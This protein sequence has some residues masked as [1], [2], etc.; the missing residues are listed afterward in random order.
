[1]WGIYYQTLGVSAGK[2]LGFH[3][4]WLLEMNAMMFVKNPPLSQGSF[5]EM[6]EGFFPWKVGQAEERNRTSL[7]IPNV[8]RRSFSIMIPAAAQCMLEI[9]FRTVHLFMRFVDKMN[10]IRTISTR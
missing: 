9:L 1:V 3:S 5:P 2:P 4:V 10:P 7:M 6:M 8:D